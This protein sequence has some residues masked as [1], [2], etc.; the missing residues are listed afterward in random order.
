MADEWISAVNASLGDQAIPFFLAERAV[1]EIPEL[2]KL[3]AALISHHLAESVIDCAPGMAEARNERRHSIERLSEHV[4]VRLVALHSLVFEGLG[5]IPSTPSGP[6][7][8]GG[9]YS[10]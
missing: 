2:A 4:M 6:H 1:N 5:D 10:E 9:Y 8:G 7:R 3:K